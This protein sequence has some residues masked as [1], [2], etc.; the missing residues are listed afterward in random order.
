MPV[1]LNPT[2]TLIDYINS[3][4]EF[5]TGIVYIAIGMVFLS[6][7]VKTN[8]DFVR[9]FNLAV[10]FI[11]VVNGI[12]EIVDALVFE[13]AGWAARI[14]HFTLTFF[15]LTIGCIA[16]KYM[17]SGIVTGKRHSQIK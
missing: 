16:L 8:S 17:H 6:R 13:G 12:E 10:T 1:K 5:L 3:T 14:A 4:G 2:F 7:V 9:L 15:Q 11:L